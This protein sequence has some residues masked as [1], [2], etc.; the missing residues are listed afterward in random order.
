MI[1]DSEL[2]LPRRVFVTGAN[3]FI[4]RAV[5]RR[6][7]ELG[8]EVCGIDFQANEEWNVVAGD[9]RQPEGWSEHLEGCDLVIHTAAVVSMVAPMDLCWDVNVH[10]TRVLL[11]VAANK[12]VSRFVHLSSIAAFGFD[13]PPDVDETWPLRP[14]G[15]SYVDTKIASEHSVLA[16]HASGEVD[17]TII[18]PGDVYGPASRAWIVEPLKLIKRMQFMLPAN[19]LGVFSPVYV[20]DLVEGIIQSSACE[21]GAGHIF[22]LTGGAGV[23]CA[24][25]FGH[26]YRWL[27][28]N[29]SVPSLP[30]SAAMALAQ[31]VGGIARLIGRTSEMGRGT[32]ELLARP[33][34]YSI[35]KAR[36]LVG[37]AP[38]VDLAEGMRRTEVWVREQGLVD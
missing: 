6:Y 22:N 14:N 21:G 23:T 26:H 17:C 7:R 37:Y 9:T 15:N 2:R 36:R 24:E 29:G 1:N 8:T 10:G 12:C 25:F 28:R 16:A 27:G 3:G 31:A 33:A 32:V 13:F 11:S 18:R 5:A 4:G 30:T 19:G 34:T 20:D 38:R 35:E